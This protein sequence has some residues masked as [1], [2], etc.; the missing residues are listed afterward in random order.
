M[1]GF[2]LLYGLGN[3]EVIFIEREEESKILVGSLVVKR[4]GFLCILRM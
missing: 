4:G 2:F 3:K 1:I